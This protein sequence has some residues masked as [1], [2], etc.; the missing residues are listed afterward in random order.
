M[1]YSEYIPLY[2]SL[3]K[4]SFSVSLIIDE[5]I[6]LSGKAID[7][8]DDNLFYIENFIFYIL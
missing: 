4:V 2:N 3:N 7:N 1:Y 6:V 5:R 8:V